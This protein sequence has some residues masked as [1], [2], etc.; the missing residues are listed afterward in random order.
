M[1]ESVALPRIIITAGEP[2]GIGP[3]IL[4][5]AAAQA[6][7]AQLV[8]AGCAEVLSA[9][10]EQLG[11]DIRLTAYSSVN[12]IA[13]HEAGVLPLIDIPTEK[14]VRAGVPDKGN[15][16]HVLATIDQAV[17]LCT[18]G[19]CHAMVTGPVQK[20]VINDTG[21]P[22]SGHTEYLRE[23]TGSDEVVML[24]T[25]GTLRV[26]LATTHIPLNRVS[27]AITPQLLT[28]KLKVIDQ[29]LKKHFGVPQ[30]RITVLGLNPHAGESGH[31]GNEELNTIKPT[32]EALC[33]QGLSIAGPVPADSAFIPSM[34]ADTDVYL[35]MYHDQGLPVLKA[36]GFDNAV[37]ITLGLPFI[38]S[39]VDHGT[40]L[41]LAGTGTASERS[42]QAAIQSAIHLA[43]QEIA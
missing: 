29:D 16:H 23:A 12:E 34:R 15:A 39:S 25:S 42:L 24:L 18:A 4:L 17:E 5:K 22:F 19:E 38:R 14:A 1:T 31:L 41:A 43:Q 9:R 21:I 33:Q 13:P 3:D 26:A 2:A 32:C 30:P 27:D 10:A 7:K 37:N 6:H 20:S 8:A 35:A 28:D 36:E 40:A 11:L